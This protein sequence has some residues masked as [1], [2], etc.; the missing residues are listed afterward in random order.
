MPGVTVALDTDEAKAV[1]EA[2]R[3]YATL[4]HTKG[5]T[6]KYV[7]AEAQTLGALKK[8]RDVQSSVL[9]SRAV[10]VQA[11]AWDIADTFRALDEVG[12]VA[13]GSVVL[14]GPGVWR[15][16]PLQRPWH[17]FNRANG[18]L[19]QPYECPCISPTGP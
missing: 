6:D 4:L 1:E 16:W 10:A 15:A 5:A 7:E 14:L 19:Q 17:N 8:S 12:A 9:A 18:L 13:R 3:R 2:N 11:T